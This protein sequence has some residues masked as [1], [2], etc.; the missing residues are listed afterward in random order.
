M[1]YNLLPALHL[2]IENKELINLHPR[3]KRARLSVVIKQNL[4][5]TDTIQKHMQCSQRSPRIGNL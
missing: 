5:F 4:M 2:K 3:L 1:K